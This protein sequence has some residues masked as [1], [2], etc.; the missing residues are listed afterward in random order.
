LLF[1]CSFAVVIEGVAVIVYYFKGSVV[2]IVVFV[3]VFKRGY[4]WVVEVVKGSKLL[5]G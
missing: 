3:I 5:V 2:T 1:A 4:L